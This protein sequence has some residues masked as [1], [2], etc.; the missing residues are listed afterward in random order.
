MKLTDVQVGVVQPH[1][2]RRQ[3]STPTDRVELEDIIR[4]NLAQGD[5]FHGA[6]ARLGLVDNEALNGVIDL[7]VRD[8]N[9]DRIFWICDPIQDADIQQR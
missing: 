5:K 2:H 8:G 6:I 7:S 9:R 1:R 3:R 4:E